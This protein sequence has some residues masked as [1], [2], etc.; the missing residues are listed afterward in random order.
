M[1]S[2]MMKK[3]DGSVVGVDVSD[4]ASALEGALLLPDSEGYDEARTLW[5]A[6]IERRPAAIVE[7]QSA[8][9]AAR[10]LRKSGAKWITLAVV[11]RAIGQQF[12]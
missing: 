8:Q 10:A 11:A 4:L 6:M 12:T 9:D 1:A 2:P 5:N 3:L 7:C